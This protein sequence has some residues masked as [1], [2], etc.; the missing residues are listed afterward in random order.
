MVN[1]D[2]DFLGQRHAGLQAR[3]FSSLSG[4][5]SFHSTLAVYFLKPEFLN[6]EFDRGKEIRNQ[7]EE[8]DHPLLVLYDLRA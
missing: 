6:D 4:L 2:Q 5:Y 7:I 3:A 1:L 8:D